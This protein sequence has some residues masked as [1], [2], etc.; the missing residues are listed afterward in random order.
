MSLGTIIGVL[1]LLT[2]YFVYWEWYSR[3]TVPKG[4]PW[5]GRRHEWLSKM[6]AGWRGLINAKSLVTEGY[7]KYSK[8]NQYFIVPNTLAGP[9]L[10]VPTSMI[11]TLLAQPD[12][13]LSSMEYHNDFMQGDYTFPDR[14]ISENRIHVGLMRKAIPRQI[15]SMMVD[16]MEE[17]SAGYDEFWGTDTDQWQDVSLHDTM[18]EIA[19]RMSTRFF[20]GPTLCR[21]REFIRAASRYARSI[22]YTAMLIRFLPVPLRPLLGRLIAVPIQYFFRQWGK[23]SFP[24]IKQRMDDL[25]RKSRDPSF[26]YKEPNDF[27]QW[28]IH[29]S[30]AHPDPGE[31]A[32]PVIGARAAIV[33]FASI[34]TSAMV[35]AGTLM[36]IYSTPPEE[37]VA[38]YLHEEVIRILG[39]ESGVWTKA[40]LQK[41]TRLDS[42][43]KETLRLRAA[44]ASILSRKVMAPEGVHFAGIYLPPGSTIGAPAWPVMHD[45]ENW[46]SPDR[47]DA[48]RFSRP[49]EE[50]EASRREA[51]A[52]TAVKVDAAEDAEEKAVL[53]EG[54]V[55]EILYHK[56]QSLLNT[57]ET[58]LAWGHGK[59]AW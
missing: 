51:A 37:G 19:A 17:I 29:V 56:N 53:N 35:T 7:Y 33:N 54:D 39:E 25:Q 44:G 58:F 15:P 45:P 14:R 3:Q 47:Y 31:H 12:E 21:N 57:S 43:V 4:V 11:S 55:A 36:D 42:A 8:N 26:D 9:E 5:V 52:Q 27:L 16:L 40:G 20:L 23:Y 34:H 30:L 18:M 1:A 2:S 13:D 59:H 49:R 38:Q 46:P 6:R 28:Q 22:V 24:L 10:L 41:M 32:G 50:F 48:F